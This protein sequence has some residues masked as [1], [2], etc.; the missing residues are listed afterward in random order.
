MKCE[1]KEDR[2]EKIDAR[3]EEE[4]IH[5]EGKDLQCM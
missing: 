1:K 2:G 3:D 4:K 5:D